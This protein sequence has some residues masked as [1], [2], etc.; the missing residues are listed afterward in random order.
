MILTFYSYKGGVGRSMALAN[1]AELLYRRGLDVLMV[2]FDLEAPGLERFFEHDEAATRYADILARR[3]IIDM[4]LSYKELRSLFGTAGPLAVQS[5]ALDEAPE[6]MATSAVSDKDAP[7]SASGAT[8]GFAAQ[9]TPQFAYSLEPLVNFL[10]EI[11]RPQMQGGSL[12]LLPAGR[13]AGDEYSRYAE[14]VRTFQWDDFYL[15]EEGEQFFDWLRKEMDVFDAVLIDSRT[16]L[17]E[18]TG[19]CTHHLADVVV[20]FAGP[21]SQNVDG[22]E[23][24]ALSLSRP[25][26]VERGRKGRPISMIMVPSRVEPGEGNKLDEFAELFKSNLAKFNAKRLTFA[27]DAFVDMRVPY[28][29]FFAYREDVACRPPEKPKAAELIAAYTRISAA[30]IELAPRTS[31]LY[32]K[33]FAQTASAAQEGRRMPVAQYFTGREWVLQR[34]DQWLE[35]RKPQVLLITGAPGTG[36]SALAARLAQ[37]SDGTVPAEGFRAIRPGWLT[38]AHFCTVSDLRSLDPKRFVQELA[39]SLAARYPAF[40][41]ALTETGHGIKVDVRQ[42]IGANVGGR[43]QGVHIQEFTSP[44]HLLAR[45][46]FDELVRRPLMAQLTQSPDEQVVLLVDGLDEAESRDERETVARLIEDMVRDEAHMPRHLRFVLTSRSAPL[47]LRTEAQTL[48]LVHDAVHAAEDVYAYVFAR[49]GPTMDPLRAGSV[50]QQIAQVAQGNMLYAKLAV[51]DVVAGR[52]AGLAEALAMALEIGHEGARAQALAALAPRLSSPQVDDA[53][54]AVRAIGDESARAY[55]LAA[56][57]PRLSGDAKTAALDE[58]L[59]AVRGIGDESARAQGLA[60]LAPRLNGDAKTAVLGEALAAVRAIGD[61]WLRSEALTALAPQLSSSRV[62]EVLHATLAIGDEGLRA[63]VLTALAPQLNSSRVD[64]VLHATLAIGDEGLRAVVL[65]ALAPQL[66]S[67]RVDEA[68]TAVGAIEDE[69]ARAYALAALAPR[70]SGDA[71]TAALDEALAAVRGIGDESARA[72]G[73]AALAPRLNGDAKTAV[74][75]EALAAVRAIGNQSTRADLLIALAPQLSGDAKTAVLGEALAAVRAIRNQSTRAD[76]LIALAPQLSGDAKTAVLGEALAAVRAI[77]D[78]S[79]RV[80]A[81]AALAPQLGTE[82]VTLPDGL[83]AFYR[84]AIINVLTADTRP[85][86][87]V[88]RP[89]LGALAVAFGPLNQAQLGGILQRPLS[90]VADLLRVWAWYLET[91]REPDSVVLFHP[92][93]RDFLMVDRD[94]SVFPDEAHAAAARYFLKEWDGTWQDADDYALHHTPAHFAGAIRFASSQA[95]RKTLAIQLGSLL[96]DYNYLETRTARFPVGELAATVET[97]RASLR[98]GEEAPGLSDAAL[99]LSELVTAVG[100]LNRVFD[101]GTAE[102]AKFMLAQDKLGI[103]PSLMAAAKVRLGKSKILDL[104]KRPGS[105]GR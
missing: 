7:S 3:G 80:Q 32:R 35:S 77:G 55:A 41:L 18:M 2:D 53:V 90:A 1:V 24:V 38:Y 5:F 31:P 26:L 71:K 88:H 72:Q 42:T 91:G 60:A 57:A 30:I 78:E 70:L 67:S 63:R 27:Q 50:A 39:R 12:Y 48:D 68:F 44:G 99:V 75:G 61:E 13:R 49:L 64:E 52:G 58:A 28:V 21:S 104:P 97:V 6:A 19:V 83:A 96:A 10:V 45:E 43:I 66:N 69:I 54:V 86:A 22:C 103:S 29:A 23:R 56:L 34:V 33:Y 87:E 65:A 15:H 73:L 17:A 8:S 11:Y 95:S 98:Q 74:L 16:G 84:Q 36:K 62:D 76:L 89:F 37:L 94:Y 25:E 92:S 93:L 85:W 40:A 14:K 9:N 59:A 47:V 51:D 79:A 4:L 105:R 81:L 102:F 20:I 82:L 101:R 100:G 46:L